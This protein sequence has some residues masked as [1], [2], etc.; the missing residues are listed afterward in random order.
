MGRRRS[1]C[2]AHELDFDGQCWRRVAAPTSTGPC[3]AS[4]EPRCRRARR[5]RPSRIVPRR[6]EEVAEPFRE[7]TRVAA[8]DVCA[9]A[10][11]NLRRRCGRATKCGYAR[12]ECRPLATPFENA[13][14][15]SLASWSNRSR[16]SICSGVSGGTSGNRR[17]RFNVSA[18]IDG[19]QQTCIPIEHRNTRKTVSW[20]AGTSPRRSVSMRSKRTG[21]DRDGAGASH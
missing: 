17:R 21:P 11:A 2:P 10:P 12:A 4:R 9:P 1:P 15:G 16:A 13:S 6:P 7:P 18:V 20:P 14:A 3:I 5:E 8:S 19:R